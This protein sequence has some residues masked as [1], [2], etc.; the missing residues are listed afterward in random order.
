VSNPIGGL[1]DNLLKQI[2]D[3]QNDVNRS[4]FEVAKSNVAR[5]EYRLSNMNLDLSIEPDSR[6]R[7]GVENSVNAAAR[8][9]RSIE[10][11]ISSPID[12]LDTRTQTSYRFPLGTII[13]S[14][15]LEYLSSHC[16]DAASHLSN[17]DTVQGIHA[18]ITN[19]MKEM[20]HW[21]DY[22]YDPVLSVIQ[23]Q[24]L[25]LPNIYRVTLPQNVSQQ[26]VRLELEK[27]SQAR[28][29]VDE[30]KK[31]V[32]EAASVVGQAN[33]AHAFEER[34]V[35]E[36]TQA[37]RWTRWV[38]S[39]VALGIILPVGFITVE[40]AVGAPSSP[41]ALALRALIGLPLFGLAAWAGRI[42][43]QH[44]ETERYL[45]LLGSQ[46]KT[47]NAYSANIT[48]AQ[49]KQELLMHLG[50][51]AFSDP[52]LATRD[53]GKVAAVPV[54]LVPLLDKAMDIAKDVVKKRE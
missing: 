49:A 33:L 28:Q 25:D 11:F 5:L 48:D 52:A 15:A 12:V 9:M 20:T 18:S 24:L 32:E 4:Q 40:Q 41:M 21:M 51:R 43:S 6:V 19:V 54:E 37:D 17:I 31:D 50:M 10:E 8:L 13:S 2:L 39:F 47:I 26:F 1:S 30:T 42:S 7:A 46:V 38:L 35:I 14:D 27:I 53:K 22:V 3:G 16:D 45:A 23:S 36:N 44:R 29:S 34:M